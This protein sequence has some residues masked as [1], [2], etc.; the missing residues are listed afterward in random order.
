MFV[1]KKFD[2]TDG[3]AGRHWASELNIMVKEIMGTFNMFFNPSR[4]DSKQMV[5]GINAIAMMN[6]WT[7]NFR[8]D[9]STFL[10]MTELP[11]PVYNDGVTGTFLVTGTNTGTELRAKFLGKS[12]LPFRRLAG[13]WVPA[14]LVVDQLYKF[15]I[16][17]DENNELFFA[18][19]N[20]SVQGAIEIAAVA[21]ELV[22][23]DYLEILED[24]S[25][26][27]PSP[28]RGDLVLNTGHI[29]TTT[30]DGDGNLLPTNEFDAV[31]ATVDPD[32]PLRVIINPE[33]ASF[34]ASER[35]VV[36][37]YTR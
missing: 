22:T 33:D 4:A 12:K 19:F 17:K 32:N 21:G 9:D 2:Y 16:R 1:E 5:T 24:Y 29:F 35:L 30:T 36:V 18:V 20:D 37:S 23:T 15:V 26:I 27:L 25:F 10:R 31:R 6:F 14:E 11:T 13:A 34:D 7:I 3:H 8:N 28:A